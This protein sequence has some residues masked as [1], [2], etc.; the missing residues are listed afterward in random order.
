VLL[1]LDEIQGGRARIV[2]P[3]SGAPGPLLSE[4]LRE[5]NRVERLRELAEDGTATGRREMMKVWERIF[6]LV[7]TPD[8][9]DPYGLI[10]L[11]SNARSHF[12]LTNAI[13]VV[14]PS[15][16]KAL[17]AIFRGSPRTAWIVLLHHQVVEYPVASISLTDRIGLAL[18]NAP[19]V[20]KAIAPHASRCLVLHGHRH[21]AWIGISK[22]VVLSSAP[23]TTMGSKGADPCHGSFY[24][25]QITAD[26]D[27]NIQL[28]TPQR[29]ETCL[30]D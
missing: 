14:S 12:A 16:L 3:A 21:R 18:V 2:D 22:G 9:R 15:Q 6:P 10:Q 1:A 23:S 26:V 13:G 24:L 7:E 8:G 11:D 17:K 5:G 27:G 29:V 20:L 4:Y 25:H 28:I 30:R 19:E